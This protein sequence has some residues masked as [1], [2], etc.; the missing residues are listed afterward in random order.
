MVEFLLSI[1]YFLAFC[2][3]ISKLSL[4]KDTNIPTQW[5]YILFGLKIATSVIL[6]AIYTYY[7][8]DRNTADIFKYFDDSKVMFDALTNKPIDYLKMLFA[9]DNNSEYFNKNYYN[10]MSYWVRP[11]N[12]DLFSDSHIIIRFN[13]FIRLF[14]F[15]HFQVHNIFMNFVSLIGLTLIY[16][17]VKHILAGKE[18]ALFFVL[19]FIPSLL[20]WGS[21]LLKEGIILFSLGLLMYSLYAKPR[22]INI[23]F[24]LFSGLLLLYTKF[25]LLVALFIPVIGFGINKYMKIKPAFSYLIASLLFFL[26]VTIMPSFNENWDIVFQI[27]NKQQA[28]SR[29]IT[30]IQT[31]SG[32]IIPELTDGVSIIKNIPNALLITIIRPYPWECSSFFVLL[33]FIENLMVIASI[34]I[35]IIHRKTIA[36]NAKSLFWFCFSF[37]LMLYILIGLTTPVFGAIIRYKIPTLIFIFILLLIVI[38][39]DKLKAKYGLLNKVL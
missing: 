36:D 28:F 1:F 29:F 15:G 12:A 26:I 10:S 37:S 14:S 20:F 38:D 17:S 27:S 23:I 22:A 31:N 4:F 7:Y 32:F 39:I 3:L 2:L 34:I 5:F 33:S 16:K 19:S 6:T 18:K 30:E 21:G 8:T 35:T 13:A 25:Y 24:L 9:I 11:Y